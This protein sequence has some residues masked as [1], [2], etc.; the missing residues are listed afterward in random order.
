MAWAWTKTRYGYYC[1][2]YYIFVPRGHKTYYAVYW[3]DQ[4]MYS[5]KSLAMA[6]QWVEDNDK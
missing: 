1:N 6:K 4:F 3:H 2:G 5:N